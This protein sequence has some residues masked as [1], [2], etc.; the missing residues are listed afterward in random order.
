[1]P[2]NRSCFGNARRFAGFQRARN[3]VPKGSSVAMGPDADARA[4]APTEAARISRGYCC[5]WLQRIKADRRY[6]VNELQVRAEKEPA[7]VAAPLMQAGEQ[8][9]SVLAD[10]PCA[11]VAGALDR[12]VGGSQADM[13]MTLSLLL[14]RKAIKAYLDSFAAQGS[15]FVLLTL[16]RCGWQHAIAVKLDRSA[17]GGYAN[18]GYPGALFDPNIGQGMYR[19]H[20][21]LASDLLRLIQ[22][23]GMTVCVRA[24]VVS[25]QALPARESCLARVAA[26]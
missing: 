11:D 12:A 20:E 22:S 2:V 9:R 10:A 19:N 13:G 4:S 24:H 26:R 21:D 25:Y 8:R 5:E 1:M 6:L 15:S 23:Y 18:W 17:A 16:S 14:S 7:A 3:L